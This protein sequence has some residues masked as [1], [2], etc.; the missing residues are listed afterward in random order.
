MDPVRIIIENRKDFLQYLKTK[1]PL[2]HLSNIFFRDIQYGVMNY[3]M[4]FKRKVSYSEA[5]GI[6]R[7]VVDELV[8][9]GILKKLDNQTWLLNYPEFQL[10]R[11]K[12]AS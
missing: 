8:K 2:Y 11:V 4:G 1:F 6:T 7:A 9:L 3:L 5:E 12:K 10:P